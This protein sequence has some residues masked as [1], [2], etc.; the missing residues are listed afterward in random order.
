MLLHTHLNT[1]ITR[2]RSE[3]CPGASGMHEIDQE[4]HDPAEVARVLSTIHSVDCRIISWEGTPRVHVRGRRWRDWGVYI[5]TFSAPLELKLS[6]PRHDHLLSMCMEG[7]ALF[8]DGNSQISCTDGSLLPISPGGSICFSIL[9][10]ATKIIN[11]TISTKAMD[12][13]F[14][15]M[16]RISNRR[17]VTLAH[18][19]ASATVS[20]QWAHAATSLSHMLHICN[21]PKAAAQLLIEHMVKI[22]LVDHPHNCREFLTDDPFKNER[23]AIAAVEAISL[24]PLRWKTLGRIAAQLKCPTNLLEREIR[25]LTGKSSGELFA[26]S[27]MDFLKSALEKNESNSF[28]GILKSHGFSIS[29]RFV[30]NYIRRFGE[31]PSTT[32]RRGKEQGAIPAKH[33]M[34]FTSYENQ[35]NEYIDSMIG[36]PISL[37]NISRVVGLSEHET[38]TVFKQ[39]FSKTPIQYVIE[40]RLERAKWLLQNTSASILSIAIECGFRTQSHLTT[41]MRK[42]IGSTPNK[43]R[44]DR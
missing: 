16:A 38:I 35:V 27:R 8:D 15:K 5:A 25:N 24:D 44:F 34:Q 12:N 13:C 20:R 9:K 29:N 31:P 23:L 2:A 39:F 11:I 22:L 30:V 36:K 4:I 6:G 42:Y 41:S 19:L 37:A 18:D 17:S 33:P 10:K 43:I 1:S 26:E 32:Y 14:S 28:V 40:R 7:L 3:E 21:A